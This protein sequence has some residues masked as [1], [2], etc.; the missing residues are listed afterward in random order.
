[1]TVQ[2]LKEGVHVVNFMGGS[3]CPNLMLC[4]DNGIPIKTYTFVDISPDVHVVARAVVAKQH[5]LHPHLLPASAIQGFDKRLAQDVRKISAM[6]LVNL[7]AKRGPIDMVAAGFPCQPISREGPERGQKDTRFPVFL[8]L[9]RIINWCQTQQGGR[10]VI[11]L[12][13]NVCIDA[14]ADKAVLDA[15]K[16]IRAFLGEPSMCIDAP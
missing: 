15:D 8:D 16:L 2:Q 10:P 11:Y 9:C 12:L 14:D 3:G 1:M 6:D 7:T 4:V 13:E 5:A